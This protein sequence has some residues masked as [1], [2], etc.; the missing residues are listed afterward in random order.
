MFRHPNDAR[1]CKNA[2]HRYRC[3]W[4]PFEPGEARC[5]LLRRDTRT[6]TSSKVR[7]W[8]VADQRR[9]A[10]IQRKSELL[11]LL[12]CLAAGFAAR[13]V[14]GERAFALGRKRPERRIQQRLLEFPAVLHIS[15]LRPKN[16][17]ETPALRR[18]SA[19]CLRARWRRDLTV[20]SGIS[21]S[22]ATSRVL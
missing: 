1:D 14:G 19:N 6:K 18:A 11:R 8:F 20:P 7:R 2:R 17:G 3:C 10:A 15:H 22:L 16:A 4:F 21:S 5:W 9:D 12:E 13:N